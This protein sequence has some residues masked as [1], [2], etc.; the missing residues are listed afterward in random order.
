[1]RGRILIIEDDAIIRLDLSNILREEG[2]EPVSAPNGAVA[3]DVL[4]IG[5]RFDLI[6]LDLMMPVMDGWTFRAKVLAMPDYASIPVIV[7]SAVN[8]LARE[9]SVLN[10]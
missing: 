1:M 2:Y 10:A 6:L 8:E 4:Q 9:I 3:L 5:T 7:L